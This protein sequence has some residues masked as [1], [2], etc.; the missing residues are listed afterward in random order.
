MPMHGSPDILP[1]L[2]ES[3]GVDTMPTID[4]PDPESTFDA[5]PTEPP[6]DGGLAVV[7]RDPELLPDEDNAGVEPAE[8]SSESAGKLQLVF[9]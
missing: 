7:S 8:G 5:Y 6:A 2:L 3:D 9:I 4:H 1:S